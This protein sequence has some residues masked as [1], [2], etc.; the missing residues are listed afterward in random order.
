MVLDSAQPVI[1]MSTRDPRGG[2]GRSTRKAE[3]SPLSVSRLSRKFGIIDVSQTCWPPRPV[4]K[5]S[6]FS[7][8]INENS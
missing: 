7:A 8:F 3:N 6:L 1:A 4:T 2:K 5:I